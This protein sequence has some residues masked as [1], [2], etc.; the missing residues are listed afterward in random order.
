[1]T[2]G[3]RAR[4]LVVKMLEFSRNAPR[5]DLRPVNPAPLSDEVCRIMA[6]SIPSSIQLR[7]DNALGA[8]IAL[9]APSDLHQL[10]VNLIVNARDALAGHGLITVSLLPV[11]RVQ[12]VC[13]GCHSRIDAS[14]LVLDVAD[15]GEGIDPSVL[16]RIFD[17]F[18]T[19]KSAGKGTGL[20]L[21][22]VHGIVHRGRGHIIVTSTPGAGTRF[23]LLFPPAF[24]PEAPALVEVTSSTPAPRGGGR[25]TARK[26]VF[27][28]TV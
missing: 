17:P 2:A 1:M 15:D 6:A 7:V 16:P 22:V 4:E 24:A 13:S 18:F 25:R 9:M 14:Y 11:Q 5:E 28:G 27:D 20:G 26:F 12:G 21:S 23:R 8:A 10:L 19:T 3:E